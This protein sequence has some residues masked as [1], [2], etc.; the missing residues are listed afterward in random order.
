MNTI[1][2]NITL[3]KDLG[4]KLKASKNRSALIAESLRQKFDQEEKARLSAVL[5]KAYRARAKEDVAL[6]AEFDHMTG[7][8]I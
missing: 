2:F 4:L 8:G 3:P 5:A 1:R 6:N 7:D